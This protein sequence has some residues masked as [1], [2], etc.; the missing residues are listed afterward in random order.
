MRALL[1]TVLFYGWTTILSILVLPL[2]LGPPRPLLAYSRFWIRGSLWLLRISVGLTHRVV[3]AKNFPDGPALFVVKHQSA[4]DTLAINL[5]VRDAAIVLKREL[6]W[7]PVFGWCL[8][9]ARQIPIDRAG[10][11]PAL[12]NMVKAARARQDDGRPIVI[13]PEGTRVAPGTR[14]PYH[15]GVAALHG[16]LDM[17]VIPVALNSGLFWPRRSLNLAAGVITIEFLPA[18]EPGLAR[19]DFVAALEAAIEPATNRLL[20]EAGMT[21][22]PMGPQ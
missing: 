20:R 6:T 9:R 12:R 15:A 8:L 21:D 19:R 17:P 1:F 14:K 11:M 3:G 16:A 2:L 13:Y 18:L 22:L 10:G 7:I 4:W 5:I